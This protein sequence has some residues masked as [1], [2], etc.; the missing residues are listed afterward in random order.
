MGRI[1]ASVAL[2]NMSHPECSIRCDALVDTG[3]SHLTLPAAWRERLGDL[4]ELGTVDV[5]TATQKI[6]SG[7]VCGPV[8]VQV[9]GF[10]AV[11]TE[12]L[13]LEMEPQDGQ[14]EP[15]VGYLV[16]EQSQAAVDMLGHRLVHVKYLDLK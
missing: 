13:F 15:L 12:V 14:Y 1:V 7:I 2:A 5:E 3:A 10:R 9:E 8:K 16:L 4:Q 11:A 6:V